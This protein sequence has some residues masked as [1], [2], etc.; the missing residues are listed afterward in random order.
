MKRFVFTATLLLGCKVSLLAVDITHVDPSFWWVGMKNTELQILVNGD[1]IA[2]S[3]I[4][5]DYP[6]VNIKEVVS[7]E[8]KNYLFI[9]LHIS[10]SAKPGIINIEFVDGT[11]KMVHPFE[12]KERNPKPGA[13]GFS[14]ADVL[15]LI[16]PDRFANGDL[17]NDNLEGAQA[18]REGAWGRHGGDIKGI[19]NHLD[20]LQDLGISTIWLNPV[21]KNGPRSYHGYAI[22][23]FYKV[24]PRYGTDEEYIEMIDKAHE[25]GMKVV[26]DMI[27]NHCGADHW[28][29]EDLPTGDWLNNNNTYVQTSHNKWSIP[30]IHAPESE[31]KRFADGWF[32]RRMPD[33]NQTNRHL[34][35]YLI[36][37]SIWWIEHTRIDGIRQDTHP[38]A[39]YDFMAR[40]CKEVTDE[41]PDFNIVGESWYPSGP[42]FSAWWQGNSK[43]SD[44][45]SHLK[46][47]MDFNLTFI[48]QT[49]FAEENDPSDGKSKGLFRIYESLAQDFLYRDTENIL[50]FLDNHDLGRFSLRE[51]PDLSKYK[52]GIAFILTTRGI[53]QLYYGTEILMTGTKEEGDGVIRTDFPGG[54]EGD[55]LNA[56]TAEGRTSEQNEAWNYMQK[57]L[58]WRKNNKAITEGKLIHY[59]PGNDDCYVYARIKDDR[60][61]LVILNGGDKEQQ[62]GMDRYSEV[63]GSYTRGVDVITEEVLDLKSHINVPAR[64]VYVM[65]LR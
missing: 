8:N 62:L 44:L 12:L 6:G 45:N 47:V 55:P 52:Q 11:G 64:G 63:I 39:D 58:K 60:T 29:M 15:Y 56:F 9:Y 27:F 22:S 2:N 43:V 10:R 16:T 65:E 42:G 3:K 48:C 57:L 19:I 46:T 40:W 53:P 4:N 25:R 34:A 20:Y 13:M 49:A 37:T 33:L 23:D 26:M 41:Y 1:N 21:Q 28:W 61:T 59:S 18:N 50:V 35:T 36:Q 17:S 30:D 14:P 31:R 24:D 32:T 51:D 7:V 54:W 5:I 38:Y